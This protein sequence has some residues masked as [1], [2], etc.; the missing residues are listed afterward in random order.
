VISGQNG[1]SIWTQ[2][3]ADN[4]WYIANGGDLTGNGINDL[5][6]GTLYQSNAAYFMDSMDGD[7]LNTI[8]TGTP[9]D[10]IGSIPDQTGD[11]SK[12]MI[13]GGRNGSIRCY[14]G[15]P[16]TLPDP[17]FITGTVV[18]S[19]GPGLV[20]D[21]IVAA[22]NASVSPDAGG[23]YVLAVSPGIYTV[24]A[25][26]PG[27]YAT[28]VANVTVTVGMTTPGINFTLEL[29]PLLPP[30]N[31]TVNA[32]TGVLNWQLPV[33]TH[34]YYP[35]SYNV[36]LD[37]VLAGNTTD[38]TWTYTGLVVNTTYTAGVAGVY[39]TGESQAVTMEF[40]YT[41]VGT[42]EPVPLVTKLFGNYPN[43][44]NPETTIHFYLA[45]RAYATIDIYNVKGEKVTRL[46]NSDLDKGDYFRTWN[47]TDEA[48]RKQ[49][50]GIYF[51]RFV[52]EG[53][54]KTGKMLLLK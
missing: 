27:Y 38:L 17:G 12:E 29:L 37:G 24:T 20:T 28:P 25:S 43:P 41:G 46:V 52:T 19:E 2:S 33:S 54:S 16:V 45:K 22:G 6:V 4:A 21:V 36:Y 48:G 40:T 10:A 7:I 5:M 49:A 3:T 39:P 34:Q 42:E 35:D 47:G 8:W 14:S 30:Q 23:N 18:V 1:Q 50:S 32:E 13:V 15:G 26:L 51:Y 44:F 53:Y 9:V 11:N 31:L